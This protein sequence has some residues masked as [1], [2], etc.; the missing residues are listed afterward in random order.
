MSIRK[1]AVRG[2]HNF[3][4][5][6]A[7]A[8]I[9]ETVEDRKVYVAVINSLRK[10][11]YQVLDVTPGNC[12]VNEDLVYGVNKAEGWGADLFISI[13]FDKAYNHYEGAL[14]TG[15]WV[16][17]L[18][19][20]AEVIAKRI[21]N[22]VANGTGLT[23]RGVKT[24]AKLYEL[25]KTSMPAVIVEVCFCEATEDVRLYH[26]AGPEKI[27][28]LIAEGIANS[29]I[30]GGNTTSSNSNSN[31]VSSSSNPGFYESS[32]T[33]TNATIVGQGNIQV[34]DENC[35]PVEGRFISP[36]DEVFVLGIYPS[37]KYVELVYPGAG[38]KYHAYIN[39]DQ[40]NRIQF[41][42]HKQYINDDGIT[43]VWWSADDVNET[44]HNEI[45]QPHQK[46]SP[47]YRTNGRLRITFYRE[48][49]TPSDGYV[50]YEGEQGTKFYQESKPVYGTVKVN[51]Y[52][53]VRSD[54]NGSVIG[55]VFN[56][57]KVLIKWTEDGWYYIQYDTPNGK[58]E[59][60]VSAQ[61]VQK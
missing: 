13:H 29:S 38:K 9:N 25:R 57:E 12:G 47:M 30:A 60:Y 44:E 61:Y 19:G 23:N 2:G 56:G 36:F 37:R 18:G 42:Y 22:S 52:L 21:V 8:L 26:Q 58:K 45:L 4:A 24:N 1:I 35:K 32:E 16:Y 59:G 10:A 6:G 33:R 14:G 46:C 15:T 7:S 5:A 20:Q 28:N 55:K 34:L 39:I 41:E 51:S 54:I 49:G 48:D 43:Y 53:N 31:N 27:G 17:G 40:Y 11:G 3:Q 50:R